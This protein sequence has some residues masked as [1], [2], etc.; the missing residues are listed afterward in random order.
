MNSFTSAR[1]PPFHTTVIL[2]ASGVIDYTL[3]SVTEGD[4]DGAACDGAVGGTSDR[5][6]EGAPDGALDGNADG[7]SD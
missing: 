1:Q 7:A 3:D 6:L 2:F 5:A 4:P